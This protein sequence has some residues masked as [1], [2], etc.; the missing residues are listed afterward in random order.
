VSDFWLPKQKI[1][2]EAKGVFTADNRKKHLALQEEY[3][4]LDIRFVFQRDNW[5]TRK[6][7]TKY[8]DWCEKN[9][10]KYAIGSI[11]EEWLNE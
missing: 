2:I 1:L 4:E 11:P 3:P 8:S 6:H 7:A 10:F 5:L 9:C